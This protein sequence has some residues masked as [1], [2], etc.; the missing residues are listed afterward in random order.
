MTGWTV[1][2][3]EPFLDNT[4]CLY[5]DGAGSYQEEPQRGDEVRVGSL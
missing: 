3:P 5:Q 4:G 2:P 1:V